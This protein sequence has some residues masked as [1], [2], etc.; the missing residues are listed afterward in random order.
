M[1][2]LNF[3]FEEPEEDYLIS[4]EE[5]ILHWLEQLEDMTPEEAREEIERL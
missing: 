3:R 4:Y 1:N 5:V 2:K